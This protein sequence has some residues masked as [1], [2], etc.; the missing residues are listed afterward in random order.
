MSSVKLYL[1]W[2]FFT[3][4]NL[5]IF[6]VWVDCLDPDLPRICLFAKRDIGRGE[7]LTFDY[8][9]DTTQNSGEQFGRVFRAE[10][11]GNIDNVNLN[12]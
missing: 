3:D 10:A 9:Q 7:Q 12:A 4:S 2:S 8:C 5:A 1:A 6:N 11:F